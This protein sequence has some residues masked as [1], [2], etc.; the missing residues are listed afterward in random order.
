M[1]SD[2]K[3]IRKDLGAAF[4]YA[5]KSIKCLPGSTDEDAELAPDGGGMFAVYDLVLTCL[6]SDFLSGVLP[7]KG[8]EI[9][10][11]GVTYQIGRT[12]MQPVSPLI[13][14]YCQNLDT[15]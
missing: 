7:K 1:H 14:I 2:F 11:T 13:K 12:N 3:R 4:V 5:G 8:E 6:K 9:E 10:F 15:Q